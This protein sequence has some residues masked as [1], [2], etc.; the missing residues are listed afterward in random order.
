MM[1][2]GLLP[3]SQESLICGEVSYYDY[4]GI[5]VDEAEMDVLARTL[6]PINKVSDLGNVWH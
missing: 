6:G 5:V 2:Q 4:K 1:K 3:I